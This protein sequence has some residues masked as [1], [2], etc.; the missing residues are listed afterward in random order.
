MSHALALAQARYASDASHTASP[1]RLLT[2]LY[3]RLVVDLSMAHDAML[4]GDVAVTGERISHAS[5]IILELHTTLDTTIWPEGESLASLYLWLVQ[6]LIQAR[7][8]KDP[9][10][11]AICRDLVIP[12]RDAWH[13]ASGGAG[14]AKRTGAQDYR[15]QGGAAQGGAS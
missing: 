14:A 13:V 1:A 5:D 10:R 12:L 3:D 9:E 8:R 2:M 6:E 15:A 11:V 4:R 7:L